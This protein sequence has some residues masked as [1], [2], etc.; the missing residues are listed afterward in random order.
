M[1][2]SIGGQNFQHGNIIEA[3]YAQE[4][5]WRFMKLWRTLA[6]P[7]KLREYWRNGN[8]EIDLSENNEYIYQSFTIRAS[9]KR[10]RR[11][12]EIAAYNVGQCLISDS[13]IEH[14]YL[15]M[16]YTCSGDYIT[17][18]NENGIKTGFLWDF[19]KVPRSEEH[20]N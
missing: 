6:N 19:Y 5:Y 18:T 12:K 17:D 13:D 14:L 2:L 4:Q 15:P 9:R 3:F 1:F 7:L 20:W 11:L 16:Y 8:L 10:L